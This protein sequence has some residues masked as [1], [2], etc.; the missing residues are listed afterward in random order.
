MGG[1]KLHFGCYVIQIGK[2]REVLYVNYGLD[3][4]K[5]LTDFMRK[6]RRLRGSQLR[7]ELYSQLPRYRSSRHALRAAVELVR[8][9]EQKGFEV[10][11][12]GPLM[13]DF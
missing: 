5:G 8:E 13:Q 3:E 1:M 7:P 4:E 6:H 2:N 12:G 10:I 9:L 11:A